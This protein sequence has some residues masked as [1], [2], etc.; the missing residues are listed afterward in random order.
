MVYTCAILKI[1]CFDI[2]LPAATSGMDFQITTDVLTFTSGQH[3]LDGVIQCSTIEILD[4][5][6]CT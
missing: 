1:Q 4:D 2:P 6:V 3:G 5:Q